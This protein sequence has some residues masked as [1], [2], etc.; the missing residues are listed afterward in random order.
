MGIFEGMQPLLA[1][2]LQTERWKPIQLH[3]SSCP[4]SSS[5][6]APG[7]HPAVIQ[8]IW[9]LRTSNPRASFLVMQSTARLEKEPI[10]LANHL[11]SEMGVMIDPA[12]ELRI[13]RDNV[14]KAPVDDIVQQRLAH[15]PC[16]REQWQLA[17]TV[18]TMW[19]KKHRC[20][21]HENERDPDGPSTAKSHRL[22]QSFSTLHF[23]HSSCNFFS[24][25]LHKENALY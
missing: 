9:D 3:P 2:P 19:P 17:W 11:T 14:Y 6:R 25:L 5:V 12:S 16:L 10:C 24:Q 15:L 7:S 4:G 21:A 1:S 23:L 18:V 13:Q 8:L 22:F 20:V